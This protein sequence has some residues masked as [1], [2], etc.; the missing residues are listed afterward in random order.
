MAQVL[1]VIFSLST[2]SLFDYTLPS[3]ARYTRTRTHNTEYVQISLNWLCLYMHPSLEIASIICV[4]SIRAYVPSCVCLI[5]LFKLKKKTLIRARNTYVYIHNAKCNWTPFRK[6]RRLVRWCNSVRSIL[7]IGV[8]Y[9]V[10]NSLLLWL[11][12]LVLR[13]YK[14][15]LHT[16]PSKQWYRAVQHQQH[17]Y[18]ANPSMDI[19]KRNHQS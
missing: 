15:S 4:C 5:Q 10:L 9:V 13:D 6:Q 3:M 2:F 14:C 12:W 19:P 7:C 8:L 18:Y 11:Y 17:H 1:T 16:L